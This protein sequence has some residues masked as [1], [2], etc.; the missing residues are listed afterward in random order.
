MRKKA[1]R[2][3]PL[4]FAGTQKL[5]KEWYKL[6]RNI[7]EIL[8]ATP[9]ITDLVHADLTQGEKKLK[10]NIEGIAS[11]SILRLAIVQQIEGLSFRE[12]IV[13][14]DDSEMLSFFCRFY[15]DPVI[16]HSK[17][18]TLVNMIAPLTWEKI[19]ELIVKFARDKK[20]FKG[21]QLRIDTTA[22]ETDIHF[23]T[24]SSLL[25]DC[26]KVLSR[27]LGYVRQI[28]AGLVGNRRTRLRHAKRLA[29]KIAR[30]GK[31]LHKATRKKWYGK[32]IA[33][34]E[35][36]MAWAAEVREKIGAGKARVTG[37]LEVIALQ[38]LAD[39]IGTYLPLAEQCVYQARE[40]VLNEQP[41]P[42]DQKIFSIFEPHTEL[43]IRG[44]AGKDVEFGHMLELQQIEGGLITHYAAHVKRPAEPPLLEKAIAR[45]K[46]LFGKVPDVCATD[47]GFYSGQAVERAE[48]LGVKKVCVPK[49]GRRDEQEEKREKS[50]WFKLAQAFRAGI[51]GTISVLKRVF[52]LWRCL[53]EGWAHFQSWAGTGVLAHNLVLLART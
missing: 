25:C 15:D 44:K 39:E 48:E 13:R 47:K 23:P 49:K 51:E 5:T 4:D 18:A 36:A 29:Q 28:D 20:G 50:R 14:V 12:V 33:A 21:K 24:D 3:L 52:G 7:H 40:R 32:L 16:S 53:R 37:P 34:T 46:D 10:R 17:Y 22:V 43:L 31:A 6:Y 42:N 35:R 9:A 30:G 8:E 38:S 2:Q 45:H 1:V 19:N 11:E 26:A 27:L 41:V